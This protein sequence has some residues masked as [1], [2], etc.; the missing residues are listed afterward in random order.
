MK[1]TTYCMVLLA[2]V[3]P[4]L[5][6]VDLNTDCSVDFHDFADFAQS[7][8]STG[9]LLPANFNGD[10]LV[11]WRDLAVLTDSWLSEQVFAQIAAETGF[12]EAIRLMREKLAAEA[13]WDNNS[14]PSAT[15]VNIPGDCATYDFSVT[16]NPSAGF[17]IT[18]TGTHGVFVKTICGT[19]AVRSSWMGIAVASTI[20][21]KNVSFIN[22]YPEPNEWIALRT[23]STVKWA[24]SLN[25]D[26]AGDIVFGP[27]GRI[28]TVVKLLPGSSV[29]GSIYPALATMN[30]QPVTAP[31]GLPVQTYVPGTSLESGV[32]ES[33]TIAGNAS[34]EPGDVT[35]YVQGKV[36]IMEGATLTVPADGSLKLYLGSSFEGKNGSNLVNC[37]QNPSSMQIYGLPTYS[38]IIVKNSG[39]LYTAIYAPSADIIIDS[40]GTFYGALAAYSCVFMNGGSMRVDTRLQ[41]DASIDDVHV[42][43]DLESRWEE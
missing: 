20:D 21:A 1:L 19:L 3:T 38:S 33:L 6:S 14:L 25:T 12:S 5:A 2:T 13:V 39:S 42:F 15:D 40:S 41:E 10:S 23:D 30:L 28:G 29:T 4:C 37:T 27:G 34:T 7:W 18:S 26:L 31:S 24:V 16:G 43:L 22:S 32:Y 17:N 11:D 35:I 8:R 9:S 36:L